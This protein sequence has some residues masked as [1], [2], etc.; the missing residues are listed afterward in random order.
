[1][2]QCVC[3]QK[4]ERDSPD[5]ICSLLVPS[6]PL[7]V[8]FKEVTN[9]SVAV[10]WQ[11]PTTPNGII[12]GYRIYYM[13]DNFTDV[14]TVRHTEPNMF[15]VLRGLSKYLLMTDCYYAVSK[16][17]LL[18]LGNISIFGIW[19]PWIYILR[20]QSV[21][22]LDDR[23]PSTRHKWRFF[24]CILK[25]GSLKEYFLERSAPLRFVTLF[26]W[27]SSKQF[28]QDIVPFKAPVKW[29]NSS[30]YT[31]TCHQKTK[32]LGPKCWIITT[33]WGSSV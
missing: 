8:I 16:N 12:V 1:M 14:Q 9:S 13:H 10:H 6:R 29:K 22:L 31:L 21:Y 26:I 7:K 18:V 4:I 27:V 28:F 32:R 2:K 11:Q 30:I 33:I 17:I 24:F 15:H 3:V 25:A 20:V 19:R 5:L 23:S